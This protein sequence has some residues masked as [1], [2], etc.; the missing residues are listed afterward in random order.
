MGLR[1]PPLA[2]WATRLQMGA[3]PLQVRIVQ[4]VQRAEENEILAPVA[5]H[6]VPM[7]YT[8][9]SRAQ[10]AIHFGIDTVDMT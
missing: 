7:S 10:I 1:Q 6:V 4:I 2:N 3:H 5:I 9:I 8:N